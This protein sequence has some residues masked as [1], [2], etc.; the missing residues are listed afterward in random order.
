[1]KEGREDQEAQRLDG[2]IISYIKFKSDELTSSPSL[3]SATATSVANV[4]TLN[5][6]Q[7]PC[8]LSSIIVFVFVVGLFLL[9]VVSVLSQGQDHGLNYQPRNAKFYRRFLTKLSR[10]VR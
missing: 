9:L 6:I 4:R 7:G 1:M 2:L 8:G 3:H 10:V 5:S